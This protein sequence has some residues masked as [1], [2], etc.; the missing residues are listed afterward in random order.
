MH[1]WLY[2][3]PPPSRHPIITGKAWCEIKELSEVLSMVGDR[4]T[5][6]Y[7]QFK[8]GHLHGPSS[9]TCVKFETIYPMTAKSSIRRFELW[10]DHFK[11]VWRFGCPYEWMIVHGHLWRL[12]PRTKTFW[13]EQMDPPW[14]GCCLGRACSH[15]GV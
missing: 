1:A 12:G 3:A 13:R 14:W 6:F 11:A 8:N 2:G 5:P 15:L 4:L 10:T 9:C 7:S